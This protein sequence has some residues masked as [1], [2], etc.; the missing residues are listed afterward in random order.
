MAISNELIKM[1]IKE[2]IPL[3]PMK[4]QKMLFFVYGKYG[5]EYNEKLFEEPFLVWQYGPV[6]ESVYYEFKSF[7]TEKINK[8]AAD[9]KG[10]AYFPDKDCLELE[11]FFASLKKTW[12]R[13]KH[14]SAQLLVGLTHIEDSPWDRAFKEGLNT[15]P[16]EYIIRYFKENPCA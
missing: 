11:H 14:L 1:A 15:I 13:Y 5:A 12:N 6:V 16:N 7:G 4:L 8:Y 9:A 3:T 10:I 2:S